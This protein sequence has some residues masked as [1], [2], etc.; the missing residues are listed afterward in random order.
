MSFRLY[1]WGSNLHGQLGHPLHLTQY[2][3]PVHIDNATTIIGATGSQI[4][5]SAGQQLLYYGLT[6]NEENWSSE[7]T[8]HLVPWD[9]PRTLIGC[10]EL[11]S[12]IDKNGHLCVGMEGKP[13]TNQS[14][15]DVAMDMRGR[16]IAITGL[17]L[18]LTKMAVKHTYTQHLKSL[19]LGTMLN[20]YTSNILMTVPNLI[21]SPQVV[22]ISSFLHKTILRH[23]MSLVTIALDNLVNWK[24]S[25]KKVVCTKYPF[26]HSGRGFLAA[27]YLLAVAT[28]I[29]SP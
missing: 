4:F 10:E 3:Q 23:C 19:F 25:H 28:D 29:P 6:A 1:G 21:R 11:L 26:S 22:L 15:R 27:S 17:Y 5:V 14:W 16:V 20:N 12:T 2:E 24:F 9:P 18:L 13:Q 7:S 8:K